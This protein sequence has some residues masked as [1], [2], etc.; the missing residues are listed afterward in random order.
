VV[1]PVPFVNMPTDQL[2]IKVY[3]N[4]VLQRAVIDVNIPESGNVQMD[5]LNSLGQKIMNVHAGFLNKGNHSLVLDNNKKLSSGTYLL[6]VQTK[7][8]NGII[9]IVVQ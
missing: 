5:L 6:K 8:S 2:V 7:S 3:P 1:T 9:K 4:P